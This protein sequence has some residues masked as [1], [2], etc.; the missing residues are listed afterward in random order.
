MK[1]KPIQGP[2][3]L[4]IEC[5]TKIGSLSLF[6]GENLLG[7]L[8]YRNAPSHAHVLVP[9]IEKLLES[10]E[11]KLSNLEAIAIS[12]GPGSYTGLRVGAS[13]AKGMCMSLD[14][15]LISMTSLEALAWQVQVLANQ[16]DAHIVPMIDARRMEVFCAVLS[17]EI[18]FVEVPFSEI[19]TEN[20]FQETLEKSKVIFVGNG[21]QK[22]KEI[23]KHPHAILLEDILANSSHMGKGAYARYLAKDFEK[24]LSFQPFYLK[25]FTPY[26]NN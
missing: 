16:L 18:S 11:L 5:S 14:I 17:K 13:I 7:S 15:P 23:L 22:A 6:D 10:M 1:A 24:I 8:Q 12:K 26:K 3:I 21:V 4:C 19:L 2:L 20:S 9:M 25:E